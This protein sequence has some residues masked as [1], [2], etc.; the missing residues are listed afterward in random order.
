MSYLNLG[1]G[2]R[3]HPAWTNVD[4][5]MSGRG[6]IVHDLNQGIPFPDG[7]FEV[8]YHSHLLEHFP[9]ERAPYFLKECYRVLQP[10]GIIRV[11]VPDLEQIARTYLEALEKACAGSAEWAAN[12]EW[13]LLEMYDQA[14][15]EKSGGGMA[16][17]LFQQELPNEEFIL[18]RCGTEARNL[19]EFGRRGSLPCSRPAMDTGPGSPVGRVS[20]FLLR[21][22]K[23]VR[24][25]LTRCLLGGD[26]HTLQVGRFRLG[27]EVH[28]WMYDHYSLAELLA[29]CGFEGA[30]PR[31]ARESYV[32]GWEGFHLD[33]EPDGRAYKPD[34]LFMEAVKPQS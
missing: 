9:R 26:Y 34:S 21:C 10:R 7:S 15:R 5:Q 17:Y 22:P 6:V 13:V 3:F 8:V 30:V 14:V 31:S 4:F 24:E 27:G 11:V 16:E 23:S 29:R 18:K 25:Y 33:T 1:C 2:S 20:N 12:Y 32:P 28:R 19:I